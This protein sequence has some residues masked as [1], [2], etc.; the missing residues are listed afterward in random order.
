MI[1]PLVVLSLWIGLQL[2][3]FFSPKVKPTI[4]K[5]IL[6]YSGLCL[7]LIFSVLVHAL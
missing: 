7:L 6:F 5:E 2:G 4:R 1:T 3:G